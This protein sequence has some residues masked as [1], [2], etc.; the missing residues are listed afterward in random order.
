MAAR[1][2]QLATSLAAGG[3]AQRD[4]VMVM[5]GNQVELSE[6]MLAVMK[7]GAVI[8]PA[9]TALEPNDL[10]AR[11]GRGAVRHVITNADQVDKFAD[12]TGDFDRIAVGHAPRP[13]RPYRLADAVAPPSRLAA[14]QAGSATPHR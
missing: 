2:D 8:M 7:L 14:R 10:A 9:T 4:R 13:W 6:S 12:I 1:S 11:I 3:V 5:L